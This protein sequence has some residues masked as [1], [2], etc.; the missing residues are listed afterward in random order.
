MYIGHT[1][2]SV[3]GSGLRVSDW[4][5]RFE[6]VFV[7][8]PFI[9]LEYPYRHTCFLRT[10][11][12]TVGRVGLGHYRSR[13]NHQNCGPGFLIYIHLW[14]PQIDL[15]DFDKFRPLQSSGVGL[16]LKFRCEVGLTRFRP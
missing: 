1:G 7:L 3:Q 6:Y 13:S 15:N 11:K 14:Y 5:G 4:R 10:P 9:P 12:H 2:L 8:L 16:K